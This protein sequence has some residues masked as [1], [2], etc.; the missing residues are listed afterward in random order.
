MM[1]MKTLAAA[2]AFAAAGTANAAIDTGQYRQQLA[3]VVPL[4][5]RRPGILYPRP[6]PEP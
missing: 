2:I 5:Q 1:K 6:R 4:G 3:G